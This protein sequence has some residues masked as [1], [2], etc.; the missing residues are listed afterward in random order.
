MKEET[1]VISVELPKGHHR[2][3]KEN[4]ANE[5]Q[6]MAGWLRVAIKQGNKKVVREKNQ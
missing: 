6:S 4:A 5:G 2:M 1:V 3:L